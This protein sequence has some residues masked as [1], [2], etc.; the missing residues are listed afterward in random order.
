MVQHGKIRVDNHTRMEDLVVLVVVQTMV[1]LAPHHHQQVIIS[2]PQMLLPI[3]QQMDGDIQVEQDIQQVIMEVAEVLEVL[4]KM[5][6]TVQQVMEDLVCNF[7]Q[8]L[9]TLLQV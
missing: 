3:P 2:L 9:E 5:Q 8:R 1:V 4:V 7:P 6:Q